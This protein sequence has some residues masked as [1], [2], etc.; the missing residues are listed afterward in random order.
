MVLRELSKKINS[1]YEEIKEYTGAYYIQQTTH[2]SGTQAQ[3]HIK[4]LIEL[5]KNEGIELQV[6]S[7]QSFEYPFEIFIEVDNLRVFSLAT[8]I[9]VKELGLLAN[10]P[11]CGKEV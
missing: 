9:E 4:D 10:C 1:V 7:R 8:V 5:S 6:E 2:A 3:T 11:V